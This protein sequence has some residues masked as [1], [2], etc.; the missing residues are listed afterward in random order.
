MA[1]YASFSARATRGLDLATLGAI[2]TPQLCLAPGQLHFAS[3]SGTM[4]AADRPARAQARPKDVHATALP[5]PERQT[6]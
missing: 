5:R 3:G 6:G 2:S 4:L 1:I